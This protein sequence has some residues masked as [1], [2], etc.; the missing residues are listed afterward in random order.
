MKTHTNSKQN[1][2]I[3]I[4]LIRLVS[5]LVILP[6]CSMIVILSMQMSSYLTRRTVQNNEAFITQIATNTDQFIDVINYATSMLMV[7]QDTLQHLRTINSTEEGYAHYQARNAL[8]KQLTDIESSIMNAVNGKIAILTTSGYLISSF[9][10]G[11][12]DKDYSLES[13]Y[14]DTIENGRKIT[15]SPLL[16]EV[17]HEIE[18][19]N[20][21]F[22]HQSLYYSRTIKSYSGN[23][24]GVIL[25]QLSTKKIW[26]SFLAKHPGDITLYLV[27]TDGGLQA[28]S[29][30]PD[31]IRYKTIGSLPEILS[32]EKGKTIHG[33]SENGYFYSAI[34]LENSPHVLIFTQPENE[35]FLANK[36]ITNSLWIA[37]VVIIVLM[38][39]ILVY[40]SKRITQ[41]LSTLIKTMDEHQ[42]GPVPQQN[43]DTA[44]HEL[45]NFVESYNHAWQ[46]VSLLM[47]QVREE[48]HL[49]E[50][51]H[52]DLLISQISPHFICNTVNSIKY[53]AAEEGGSASVD[54]LDALSDI[55]Q[56][57]YD[58]TS[59]LT[60]IAK[61]LHLLSAYVR[62]M[63]MRFGFD[64]SYIEN[65]PA[66]LFMCEI[67]A[68]TLQP[69][70]E[71]AFLH[72][73]H[74]KQAGQIILNADAMENE[75]Q[76][77]VFNNG[78]DADLEKV[79]C[80]LAGNIRNRSQFTGFGL[81][82]I[83]SR[84]KT[85]YGEQYGLSLNENLQSGFEILVRIPRKEVQLSD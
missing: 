18:V 10:I 28:L 33:V 47:D 38:L 55:L 22:G 30:N 42:D 46:R 36:A 60:I 49:R 12:A 67:P 39:C 11:R 59:D 17:F 50:K 78:N 62:I 27:N 81:Y 80:A 35:L 77:S 71:N 73:V 48:T 45:D 66:E 1:P 44:F 41:P 5:L 15:F 57:V 2:G 31:D 54:A 19:D 51:A 13:W 6:L 32:L 56:S 65:I 25:T 61:E 29:G 74:E 82:N 83:N 64:I 26:G 84:L 43:I 20:Q 8:S 85:L 68:F 23:N 53:L 24:L 40:L 4:S 16:S 34:R 70:V 37:T 3:R 52:Y 76:I 79:R 14:I 7:N 9:N 58:N 21:F 72:G 69:L 63:R 75:I